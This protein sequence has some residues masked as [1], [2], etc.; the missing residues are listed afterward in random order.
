MP[1]L[2][3]G[4]ILRAVPGARLIGVDAT[5]SSVV[6]DSRS[7]EPGVA[8][9]AINTG[10]DYVGHALDAGAPFVIV[11]DDARCPD[12]ATAI[13]VDDMQSTLIAVAT[14]STR[15][16]GAKVIGITGSVGKT[17]T[18]DLIAAALATTFR[19]HATPRSY[20]AEIGVPLTVL[21]APDDVEVMVIEMGARGVGQIAEL[22]AIVRPTVGVITGIG[23]THLELFGTRDAIARTKSELLASLP[24]DGVA[25]VPSNDDF[26]ATLVSSTDARSVTVG[27]GGNV[28]YRAS[29]VDRDGRTHGTIDDGSRERT[30]VLPVAGRALMRNAALAVTA[31]VALGV[32]ADR[33]ATALERA[34]LSGNRM[35]ISEIGPW[36]VVNDTYNAN[37]ISMASAL[38]TTK[39]LARGGECWA[40]LGEMAELGPDADKDHLRIGRLA[41]ALGFRVI[42]IGDGATGIAAGAGD[43]AVRVASAD[44]AVEIVR[45]TIPSGAT[46]LVKASRAIA[47]EHLVTELARQMG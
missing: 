2:T 3:T 28:R 45:T 15:R 13:V 26:L 33:A 20:N 38:R 9:A 31:T 41:D 29:A 25:I 12:G 7:V 1:Q 21:G 40:V 11:T 27:P 6:A 19:V 32:D 8:F 22:S 5:A 14:E 23:T 24:A 30:V 18:K 47:L 10:V 34:P 16:L 37:P 43:D 42:A 44:D 4:D 39:E 17:L 35:E 46:I 36:T